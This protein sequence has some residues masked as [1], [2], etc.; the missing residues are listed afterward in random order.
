[1]SK[2]TG[3][4]SDLMNKF[5]EKN[6]RDHGPR[7]QNI[8]F[9]V[10]AEQCRH[11]GRRNRS[12]AKIRRRVKAVKDLEVRTR[13][14]VSR[15]VKVSWDVTGRHRKMKLAS[16]ENKAAYEMHREFVAR[17]TGVEDGNNG[18][19]I[20]EEFDFEALPLITPKMS[21][22]NN[23]E[24]FQS[25]NVG[26]R[27]RRRPRTGKPS[28]APDRSETDCTRGIRCDIQVR[29]RTDGGHAKET[30][31]IPRSEKLEPPCQVAAKFQVEANR[32][33]R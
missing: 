11:E 23:G 30:N 15:V 7:N 17:G 18:E 16:D 22:N 19:V 31:A 9:L 12:R 24:K 25:S 14:S 2:K 21:G 33:I 32:V 6:R 29:Q 3:I 26:R 27:Y 13:Q 1:M 4:S 28:V 5:D 20:A 8:A 10:R